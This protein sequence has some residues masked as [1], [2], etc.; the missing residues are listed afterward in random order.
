MLDS[1]KK[2]ILD[3]VIRTVFER[4]PILK[5]GFDKIDNYKTIIGRVGVYLSL[6]LYALANQFPEIPYV[7][8][9]YAM[10]AVGI[11]WVFEQL[12]IL[13]KIDKKKRQE[14]LAQE[15]GSLP[16]EAVVGKDLVVE[17]LTAKELR[18]VPKK[19]GN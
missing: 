7:S 6:M 15:F 2:V 12:G 13:H 19:L 8:E 5:Q 18:E 9:T 14:L 16:V 1:I 4:I 17:R 10:Y 11:A 3:L